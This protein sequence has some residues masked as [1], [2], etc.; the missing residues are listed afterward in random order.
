MSKKNKKLIV[1]VSL[2]AVFVAVYFICF[3]D[4]GAEDIRNYVNSYGY[5]APIIYIVL[6]TFLPIAFFPVPIL[7]LAAGLAF[8][9]WNGTFYTIIGAGLNSAIMYYMA[10]FMAKDLV[11]EFLKGKLP[12]KWLDLFEEADSK[13][14]F[15]V[16]FVLRLIP[17]AP[18]NVINYGAGL[19]SISFK[20]YIVATLIGILPGTLVFLNIGDK[21][22]DV[23]NPAFI[24]SIALL[25]MLTAGSLYLAKKVT[26]NNFTN[27]K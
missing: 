9:L 18:Y 2:I 20:N 24:V 23:K 16:V 19:T 7:A 21:A 10:K 14:G 8:G 5:C 11:V 13:S 12:E 15:L 26:P 17:L 1:T 25:A 6:F 4:I 27:K 22:I 3:R